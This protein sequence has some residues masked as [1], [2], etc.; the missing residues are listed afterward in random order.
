M[1]HHL[2]NLLP[3]KK[4][5]PLGAVRVFPAAPFP[6]VSLVVPKLIRAPVRFKL[7]AIFIS[8]DDHIILGIAVLVFEKDKF[9][10]TPVLKVPDPEIVCTE[11]PLNVIFP[12]V[13][14]PTETS[15]LPL[16][17]TFP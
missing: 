17:V 5:V 6:K 2:A 15:I 11:L 13:V 8:L 14:E 9:L 3:D 16:L 12:D 4:P 10:I 7:Y 1:V